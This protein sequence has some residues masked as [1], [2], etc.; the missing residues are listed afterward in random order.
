MA[1]LISTSAD[2]NLSIVPSAQPSYKRTCKARRLKL[3]PYYEGENSNK[4]CLN[5][6]KLI[7]RN[8]R[9]AGPIRFKGCGLY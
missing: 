4:R 7:K 1:V 5:S 8:G 6:Y 3:S 2:T 9:T